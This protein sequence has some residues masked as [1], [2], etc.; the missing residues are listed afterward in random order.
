MVNEIEMVEILV[1][2]WD[3][4]NQR[5]LLSVCVLYSFDEPS[6]FQ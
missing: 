3:D 1:G 6:I 4:F 2:G 5:G